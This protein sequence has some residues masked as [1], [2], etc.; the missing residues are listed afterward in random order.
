VVGGL[1]PALLDQATQDLFHARLAEAH[2]LGAWL[3][4]NGFQ[5]PRVDVEPLLELLLVGYWK[6]FPASRWRTT[7]PGSQSP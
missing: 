6:S 5:A 2:A 3:R 1:L 4:E 7:L